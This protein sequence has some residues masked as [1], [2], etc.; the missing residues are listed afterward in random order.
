MQIGS[1]VFVTD[2]VLTVEYDPSIKSQLTSHISLLGLMW[3]KFGRKPPDLEGTIP[4]NSTAWLFVTKTCHNLLVT[5]T[6]RLLQR[7][8]NVRA[9]RS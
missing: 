3:C 6:C 7:H 8:V 2:E 5:K 1:C 9:R 4:S